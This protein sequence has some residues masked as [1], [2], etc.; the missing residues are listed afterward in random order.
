MNKAIYFVASSVLLF[1]LLAQSET[2]TE[3]DH[4]DIFSEQLQQQ[5]DDLQHDYDRR[6]ARIEKQLKQTQRATR[7]KKANAFNPA[8]SLILNGGYASYS[9][10]SGDYQLPGFALGGEAGLATEGF[11]LD[12]S[13]MTLGANVDQVF[14]GQATFSLSDDAGKTSIDTE[15]AFFE[16]LA[17]PYGLKVKAGR[18]F[19]AIGYI[20]GKHAHA[21]DFSDA[22]LVY[23]GLFGDQL[24]QD[25]VQTSWLLPTD[26]YILMGGEV[27]NGVHYPSAGG[28]AN[29]GDWS[30]YI[31]TGGDIGISS[32]WQLGLSH[33]Q[34][35]NIQNRASQG[36][37]SPMFDG[38][39][40]IN[41]IDAV[42]KWAPNGN[43]QQQNLKLQAEY[44]QRDESG[45]LNLADTAQNS[46]YNGA[47]QGWYAQAV[48]QFVPQWKVGLRYDRVSSDN[49]GSDKAVL[50]KAG[51]LENG[52]TAH[53]SSV[54]LAW[55]P[56]E[57]SR[58]RA[59]YNR[60]DSGSNT[61]NQLFLQYTMVMGAHGAH[62]Y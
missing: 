62:S 50:D 52:H 7:T 5:L 59:Q 51:L 6:L 41:G 36:L 17:L 53:R 20:N 30:A 37:D 40:K 49:T 39:S 57:F 47:Q 16:T 54:M 22:P 8:I 32:S 46:S 2:V 29:I 44:F 19:S 27:G 14:Y 58:I 18:F 26:T 28:G 61:D 1:P 10:N 34:A 48:Y 24:K 21:W 31:K 35:N 15:E 43:P 11:S 33:W 38:N 13:E 55:R 4:T 45:Q 56:S 25:G 60:D 12:E 23:R 42:Y 9:N 3:S